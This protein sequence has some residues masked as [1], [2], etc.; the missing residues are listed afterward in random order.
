M[1]TLDEVIKALEDARVQVE[2]GNGYWVG[3]RDNDDLKIDALHYLREYREISKAMNPRVYIP[4]GYKT[5]KLGD[6]NK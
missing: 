4:D 6:K 2:T 1:K 3:F 5:A